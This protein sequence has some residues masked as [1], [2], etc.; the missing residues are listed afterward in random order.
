MA[1]SKIMRAVGKR[2]RTLD[3]VELVVNFADHLLEDVFE[4]GEAEDA[5]EFVDNHGEARAASAEFEQKFAGALR[6][7]DDEHVA[8]HCAQMKSGGRLTLF[9]G[10][11]RDR[12]ESRSCP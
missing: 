11:G 2:E 5:A 8:Q 10:R 7:G 1:P 3:D 12:A 4:R 9:G 6:F